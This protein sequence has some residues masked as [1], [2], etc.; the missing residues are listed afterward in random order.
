MTRLAVFDCDGT[1]I[2]GQAAVCEAMR[3][4]FAT[5]GLPVPPDHDIRRIVGLSLPVAI[6]GL[7][8]DA[9]P[10]LVSQAVEAYRKAI[11]LQP[12]FPEAY[13]N[14]GNAL[15]KLGQL[16]EASEAYHAALGY[17]EIY[18]EAYNNL[19]TNNGQTRE[20]PS[21]WNARRDSA[22]RGRY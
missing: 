20:D 22:V 18:P 12:A 11:V 17:R 1:L 10:E 13:N 16:E 15:R 14:L 21:R 7:A 2:D 6:R 4:G 8:P 5:V 3:T 19:G 9:A